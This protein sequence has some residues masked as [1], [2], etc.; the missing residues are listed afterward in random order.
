MSTGAYLPGEPLTNEDLERLA[1]P[2]PEDVLEGL[3]VKTRHWLVDPQTGEHRESN[4]DMAY[5]AAKEA[6][7]LAGLEPQQVD[8]LVVST[9]SP[10][11]HLPATAVFVQDKLGLQK[12]A[13]LE[14]RSGC[15]GAVEALDLARLYLERGNYDT[16]VVIGS[17]AISPLLVPIYLGKN[18][19][20][21]RMRDRL[22]FYSFGDGAGAMVL[23]T[24]D[25]GGDGQAGAGI[26]GS[27]FACVGGGK[28]P[29]MQVIGGGTH[30]PLHKQVKAQRLI[31]LRVDVVE[32]GR[33]T[34]YVLTEALKDT[35]ARSGVRAEMIDLCV[36]PEGNA[37][38]MTDELREAGLLTPEFT[39]LEP[40]IFE[41]LAMVGA[42]GSAAVP[43]AMDYAWKTG[44]VAPGDL[45]MLLA[46]ETSK[47]IYAGMVLPWTA[48]PYRVAS[49]GRSA[50]ASP[51]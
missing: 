51:A 50:A 22:G 21:V 47:W 41:N 49:E 34:P 33:Y 18:P 45:V 38:Y 15:A 24:T 31:E 14:V 36:I 6:L 12:C 25:G 2:V 7:D 16:A 4:S 28:K 30:M 29:G 13:I 43:L 11:Y 27:A 35:L 10:D 1:G 46:L 5:K 44:K 9:S 23:Q 37:G 17:E 20:S 48:V 19:D 3:Q 42:T 39:A 8:L 40:K 26:L 32:S